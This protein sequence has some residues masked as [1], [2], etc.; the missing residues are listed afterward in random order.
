MN[1][2]GPPKSIIKYKTSLSG[3]N[4]PICNNY[5][6]FLNMA[7]APNMLPNRYRC[8]SCKSMLGHRGGDKIAF[9]LMISLSAV[10]GLCAWLKISS[11]VL[12]PCVI[13]LVIF[14]VT[15]IV[16]YLR[17]YSKLECYQEVESKI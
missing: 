5:L 3:F 1:P 4:C 11:A 13:F 8:K 6:T 17:K 16:F 14:F 9:F 2:F 15:V 10:G 12:I 7:V